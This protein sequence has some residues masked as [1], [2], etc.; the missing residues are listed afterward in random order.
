MFLYLR[1]PGMDKHVSLYASNLAGDEDFR[2]H[3]QSWLEMDADR[4][5]FDGAIN[6]L[7]DKLG[8]LHGRSRAI[9]LIFNQFRWE[10]TS[11]WE[12]WTKKDDVNVLQLALL[13]AHQLNTPLHIH[14]TVV[15]ECIDA[16][17]KC[18]IAMDLQTASPIQNP[19]R[20]GE[21][22]FTNRDLAGGQFHVATNVQLPPELLALVQRDD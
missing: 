11:G 5:R 18:G 16:A 21:F 10:D 8:A 19:L 1:H 6:R 20:P 7:N 15:C 3:E 13:V 4:M 2:P 9:G 14:D 17:A 22:A 12:L